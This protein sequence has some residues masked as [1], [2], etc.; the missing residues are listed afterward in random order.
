[1]QSP[2]RV[3]GTSR[4]VDEGSA[5][6]TSSGNASQDEHDNDD[7]DIDDGGENNGSQANTSHHHLRQDSVRGGPNP[8]GHSILDRLQSVYPDY[9]VT[10]A[11][12]QLRG[13]ISQYDSQHVKAKDIPSKSNQPPPTCAGTPELTRLQTK[14]GRLKAELEADREDWLKRER[15]LS[16]EIELLTQ[17]LESRTRY[18]E[19]KAAQPERNI[20]D[21]LSELQQ[22]KLQGEQDA[23]RG[24]DEEGHEKQQ[25]GK[26]QI[27]QGTKIPNRIRVAEKDAMKRVLRHP[28]MEPT[29]ERPPNTPTRRRGKRPQ[30][31]KAGEE[32]RLKISIHLLGYAA[33]FRLRIS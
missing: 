13:N 19:E 16:G 21:S 33:D 15:K 30:H 5:T 29:P 28:V 2:L 11:M 24:I 10:Y 18:L 9:S 6:Q 22:A 4:R 20:R 1:M 32:P 14:L 26:E 27:T 31:A 17:C 8:S 12:D 25:K 23:L 3:T 7:G